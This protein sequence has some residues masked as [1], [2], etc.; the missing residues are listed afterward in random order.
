[1]SFIELNSVSKSFGGNT[2]VRE[3]SVSVEKGE[4]LS[5]LG[6]SGCGKTTTLRMIAG[7]ESPSS[8]R[9]FISGKDVSAVPQAE[10]A[11][12]HHQYRCG[13]IPA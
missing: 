13:Q 5:L 8:G 1:M 3:L 4:F 12:T 7:F 6:G 9:V 11:G 2:V 10:N